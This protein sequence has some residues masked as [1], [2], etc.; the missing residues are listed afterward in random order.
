MFAA[1]DTGAATQGNATLEAR[2]D[3]WIVSV[4]TWLSSLTTFFFGI[5]EH[6]YLDFVSTA[7]SGVG[8]HSDLLDVFARYGIMGGLL[9]YGILIKYYKWL[10]Q[11]FGSAFKNYIL[12]FFLLLIL[13]GVTKRFISG[14]EAIVIFMLLPLC[15]MYMKTQTN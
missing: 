1:D 12:T 9:L 15:L 11:T 2:A 6:N 10:S 8:N 14:E 7:A 13:M 5:G 4:N 3:L